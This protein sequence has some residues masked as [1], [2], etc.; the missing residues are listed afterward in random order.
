MYEWRDNSDGVFSRLVPIV[1]K[2]TDFINCNKETVLAS[3]QS[4][5]K[6]TVYESESLEVFYIGSLFYLTNNICQIK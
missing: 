3:R 2:E 6:L 5:L 1:P 4:I